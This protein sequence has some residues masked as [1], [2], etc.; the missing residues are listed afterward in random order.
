MIVFLFL[1]KKTNYQ[2]KCFTI[3][4]VGLFTAACQVL[5]FVF[6]LLRLET[7]FI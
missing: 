6:G 3:D 4:Q 7:I 1:S 2:S 5:V